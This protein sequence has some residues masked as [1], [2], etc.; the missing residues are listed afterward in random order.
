MSTKEFP[1][2]CVWIDAPL[3]DEPGAQPFSCLKL[4]ER[5][6]FRTRFLTVYK[7]KSLQ[8]KENDR[9]DVFFSLHKDDVARFSVSRFRLFSMETG[10]LYGI[11]YKD[12][13]RTIDDKQNFITQKGCSSFAITD[14]FDQFAI[15]KIRICDVNRK[16][17]E[18]FAQKSIENVIEIAKQYEIEFS[19]CRPLKF[20][21]SGSIR[22]WE[23]VVDNGSAGCYPQSILD[24]IGLEK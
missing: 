9:N 23:D 19:D 15:F 13:Q 22:W 21:Q 11:V 2:V 17:H 12:G 16:N 5:F 24:A 7:T 4:L 6:G 14:N 18:R 10:F 1:I 8:K 20:F 3:V